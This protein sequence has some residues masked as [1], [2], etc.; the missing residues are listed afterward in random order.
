MSIVKKVVTHSF[1]PEAIV[2]SLDGSDLGV[3]VEFAEGGKPEY[4]M[5]NPWNQIEID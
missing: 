4:P 2:K 1:S 5:K 3:E